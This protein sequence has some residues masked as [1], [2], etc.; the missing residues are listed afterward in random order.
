RGEHNPPV[1][2]TAL[3][4]DTGAGS[5]LR[6]DREAAVA[7]A[8]PA[9]EGRVGQ[10]R[11]AGDGVVRLAGRLELVGDEAAV[12]GV[13][14]VPRVDAGVQEVAARAAER[15]AVVDAG[16]HLVPGAAGADG[17]CTR[18]QRLLGREIPRVGQA[19][20]RLDRCALD[21][22]GRAGRARDLAVGPEAQ[23]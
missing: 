15:E 3:V 19:G 2:P 22:T 5:R 18:V 6:R 10:G 13:A 20:S 1:A 12:R 21:E 7:A 14:A 16:R 8:T 23:V 17:A 4:L 9:P 11:A